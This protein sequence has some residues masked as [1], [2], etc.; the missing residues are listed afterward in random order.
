MKDKARRLVG[1]HQQREAHTMKTA[2]FLKFAAIFGAAA[3]FQHFAPA[4]A[5][6]LAVLAAVAAFFVDSAWRA[7][8][9]E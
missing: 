4:W 8:A 3:F 9:K 7:Q 2:T 1:R 5:Q 6:A